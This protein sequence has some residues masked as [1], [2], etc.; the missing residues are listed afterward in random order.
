MKAEWR[1]HWF[2]H[3]SCGASSC[4]G[5]HLRFVLTT[6]PQ[7]RITVI[8]LNT[9]WEREISLEQK[10]SV[11]TRTKVARI[12]VPVWIIQKKYLLTSFRSLFFPS[13]FNTYRRNINDFVFFFLAV[14]S[15]KRR[16]SIFL[17]TCGYG[18]D[19]LKLIWLSDR[20][21]GIYEFNSIKQLF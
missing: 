15:V 9:E 8:R 17:V 1:E 10:L 13:I 20:G 18:M 6:T 12:I 4:I 7:Y 3:R 19:D 11:E 5:A 2:A 14:F 16:L 21:V